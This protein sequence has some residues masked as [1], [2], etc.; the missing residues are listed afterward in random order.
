MSGGL[1]PVFAN[2]PYLLDL[3]AGTKTGTKTTGPNAGQQSRLNAG[4]PTG[5]WP[6]LNSKKKKPP[7][8]GQKIRLNAGRPTGT[9]PLLNSKKKT[10]PKGRPGN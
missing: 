4:R 7:K 3:D 10:P 6:L 8:A 2:P 5:A 1:R 9:W